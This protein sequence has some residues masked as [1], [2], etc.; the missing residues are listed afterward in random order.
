MEEGGFDIGAYQQGLSNPDKALLVTFEHA[1][2]K[3]DDGTFRNVE[4]I[5]IWLGKNDEVVRPV[6]EQDK[7]RFSERY[8]AFRAGEEAP[9]EGTPIAQCP[10]ATPADVSACKAERIF[11]LEQ[12][13]ELPDERLQRARL[14]NF[15]YR[16]RDFVEATKRHGY[17]GELR[18]RIERL[19]AENK[20]LKERFAQAGR[21]LPQEP[22][23][24]GRPPKVKDVEDTAPAS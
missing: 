1:A 24:R 16:S 9:M 15:K 12:L 8:K 14:V 11:T 10:F 18:T 2:F 13:I 7:V 4:M 6:T 20:T 5:R 23:R 22:K 3:N 21:E 17:V 19:E